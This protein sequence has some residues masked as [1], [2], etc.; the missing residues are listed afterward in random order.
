ML[1]ARYFEDVTPG[2]KS[3]SV[4]SFSVTYENLAGELPAEIAG[5]LADYRRGIVG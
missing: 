3:K 5:L 4:A 1:L 2:V